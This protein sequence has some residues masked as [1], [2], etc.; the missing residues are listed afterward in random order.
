[1]REVGDPK[2]EA[3]D[4]DV[5]F[6]R[7]NPRRLAESLAEGI[8]IG[9]R[10][11]VERSGASEDLRGLPVAMANREVVVVNLRDA[12]V[13]ADLDRVIAD[14]DPIRFAQFRASDERVPAVSPVGAT[15]KESGQGEAFRCF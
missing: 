5:I 14:G 12:P 6:A 13:G 9:A 1:M 15:S 2:A 8:E 4:L 7:G 10:A 3:S 11:G